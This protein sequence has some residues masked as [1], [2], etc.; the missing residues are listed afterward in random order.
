MNA[1]PNSEPSPKKINS[2]EK[3]PY[4]DSQIINEGKTE[5]NQEI[6]SEEN[7]SDLF[8]PNSEQ[9]K[10]IENIFTIDYFKY[11]ITDD[12]NLFDLFEIPIQEINKKIESKFCPGFFEYADAMSKKPA[13]KKF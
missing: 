2:S 3:N 12:L 4:D 13:K 5:L 9:N 8:Y 10:K 1:T 7:L 6:N 11:D